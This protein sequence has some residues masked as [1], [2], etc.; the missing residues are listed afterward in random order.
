MPRATSALRFC[1]HRLAVL[2]LRLSLA[3]AFWI[4]L[5]MTRDMSV[6]T[7]QNLRR[8]EDVSGEPAKLIVGVEARVA[9][10]MRLRRRMREDLEEGWAECNV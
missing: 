3:A 4:G 5:R 1:L 8:L 6:A 2:P 9:R 7:W 10:G